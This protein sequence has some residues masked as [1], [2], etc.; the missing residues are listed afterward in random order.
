M[1]IGS[2]L[3]CIHDG[4][5][6]Y[7]P[8]KQKR[9]AVVQRYS[10]IL[11]QGTRPLTVDYVER[12]AAELIKSLYVNFSNSQYKSVASQ[13]QPDISLK[14]TKELQCLN[15]HISSEMNRL[16]ASGSSL[17]SLKLQRYILE[18]RDRKLFFGQPLTIRKHNRLYIPSFEYD[19][20]SKASAIRPVHKLHHKLYL[21]ILKTFLPEQLKI[22]SGTFGLAP[23]YP[24]VIL[25]TSRFIHKSKEKRM[26]RELL[27]KK[28]NT[29][30][31]K[32]RSASIFE[33]CVRSEATH[34]GFEQLIL[35]NFVVFNARGMKSYIDQVRDYKIKAFNFERLYRGL[36]NCQVM[37]GGF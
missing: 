9:Q 33:L 3:D 6:F 31:S 29:G 12:L 27:D 17:P 11:K 2:S 16:S 32:F 26:Y 8:A 34:K 7:K 30:L 20:L 36:E 14:I 1:I 13:F 18:N 5:I 4:N 35:N 22:K 37:K 28:G 24:R 19:F 21:N 10:E 25:E 15:G 23:W